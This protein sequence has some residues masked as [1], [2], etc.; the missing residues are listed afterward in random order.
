[1]APRPLPTAQARR[2]ALA[3]QGFTAPRP[4]GPVTMRHL[5][6]TVRRLG[7]FQIDSVNVLQRAHFMPLYS[8]RGPY[9]VELLARAAERRPRRVFEYWAHVATYVDIGLFPAMRH[10]MVERRGMWGSMS[11]V[12]EERPELVDQVLR[13]VGENGPITARE[14]EALLHGAV[15]RDRSHW[16]WNWSETKKALEYLFF[17]GEI[18]AARR[19]SAFERVYD[20]TER[21]IPA[22]VYAR[23]ALDHA[24]AHRELVEHAARALGVAT[25]P[26]LR[27]YFR[28]A[29]APTQ[30]AVAELVEDGT[31]SPIAV[32][33][34]DRP[35]YL[36][37]EARRPR[38]VEARALL[39]PF[40]PLVFERT[41][42]EQI[43]DFR[44]RIEIYVPGA[45]RRYGYY[46]LPFLLGDR[47]AGRVDLK[48]D[49]AAGVLDVIGA[50]AE[51]DAPADVALQLAEEL[52]TLSAW[53]GLDDIR[54]PRRG[55]LAGALTSELRGESVGL[56]TV[57]L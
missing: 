4:S 19:N 21:I 47:I 53:L 33:G 10:R 18:S 16:G 13:V 11:R 12:A 26:C 14:T 15:E 29:P 5:S 9:D 34:W 22:D 6:E 2:I 40:D 20:L 39:S 51:P 41:R 37:A 43:F 55:D 25:E 52:R 50:W 49:R 27:D 42:A 32:Q 45:K 1:M 57:N 54:A 17:I 46:V 36:H 23:P 35:A 31:L 3:A 48:A 44:Y 28:T 24:D 7:F 56:T 8:R 30:R 38:R